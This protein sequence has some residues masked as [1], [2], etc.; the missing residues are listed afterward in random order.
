MSTGID[1]T[2]QMMR[3][4]YMQMMH[5]NDALLKQQ[6]IVSVKAGNTETVVR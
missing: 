2:L 1:Q 4:G 3:L 6:E 5:I